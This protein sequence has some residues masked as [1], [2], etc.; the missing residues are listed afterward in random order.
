MACGPFA[1]DS[2]AR[3]F[4][5]AGS[6]EVAAALAVKDPFATSGVFERCEF[7]PWKLVFFDTELLRG[8]G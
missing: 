5:E 3:F 7:K 6:A 1:E 2:G 4:Y 8:G